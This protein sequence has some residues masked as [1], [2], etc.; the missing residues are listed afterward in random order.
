MANP[1]RRKKLNRQ[2]FPAGR[3]GQQLVLETH[4]PDGIVWKEPSG[5]LEISGGT[6][7]LDGYFPDGDYNLGIGTSSLDSLVASKE[8]TGIFTGIAK[9]ATTTITASNV[10]EANDIIS[11]AEVA[12]SGGSDWA[13]E[14]NGKKFHVA[15]ATSSAFV[16][17]HNTSALTD[18]S[19]VSAGVG[20]EVNASANVS[21]GG[22]TG[23][24]L[25]NELQN[26][27]VGTSAGQHIAS[28]GTPDVGDNNTLIGHQSGMGAATTNKATDNTA[29]G[30]CSLEG[31]TTGT[32]NSFVGK[33]AGFTL[34]TGAYNSGNGF[35]SGDDI[36]TGTGNV[37]I[38]A[39]SGKGVQT[40]DYN[41]VL[42]FKAGDSDGANNLGSN[43]LVIHSDSNGTAAPATEAL[44]YGDFSAA[45]LAVNGTLT[46]TMGAASAA[47]TQSVLDN[48]TKIATTAYVDRVALGPVYGSFS[49]GWDTAAAVTHTGV[50]LSAI[51]WFTVPTVWTSN[52]ASNVTELSGATGRFQP[53]G[54][55][56]P[57]GGSRKF[58]INWSMNL[59]YYS[60]STYLGLAGRITKTPSGG[61]AAEVPGSAQTTGWDQY[62]GPYLGSYFYMKS[63]ASSAMV[64]L[65]SGD[66]VQFQ[67]G[68][69]SV[70]G[71]GT[72]TVVAYRTYESGLSV[73]IT[74]MD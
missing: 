63:V 51:N 10:L 4:S 73:N 36:T 74:A 32:H 26:V 69:N 19:S 20:E 27:L 7:R 42:G 14:L 54:A 11:I 13:T 59:W 53:D 3:D 31:V 30:S 52:L 33:R 2:Q 70:S 28:G 24:K 16:I 49:K 15:S 48:S 65:A 8:D 25:T 72:T 40:G 34:T 9:G 44:I 66:T 68:V 6:I 60:A 18:P 21:V 1:S 62:L 50:N 61:P 71:S 5:N 57:T 37:F 23:E 12:T 39:Q 35:E 29:I 45:T 41:V 17:T 47:T 22:K 64:S 46:T 67:Y 43:K 55:V 58:L 38:G 56:I